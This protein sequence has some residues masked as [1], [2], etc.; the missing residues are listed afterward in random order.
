MEYTGKLYG[1]T[2]AEYFDTGKTAEHFDVT[3]HKL[4]LKIQSDKRVIENLQGMLKRTEEA[5]GLCQ[6]EIRRLDEIR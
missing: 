4:N 6:A 2:G 3:M 5:Y 1:K